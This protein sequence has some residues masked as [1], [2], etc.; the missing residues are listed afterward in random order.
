MSLVTVAEAKAQLNIDSA[1]TTY[2]TELQTYIDATT[3]VVEVLAGTVVPVTRTNEVY[4]P[5]GRSRIALRKTPIVSISSV[6]EYVGNTAYTLTSQ[7]LASTTDNYGYDLVDSNGGILVRRGA[8]GNE[9]PFLGDV[10]VTYQAGYASTPANVKLAALELIQ[11][12]WQN[13]QQG[14][15]QAGSEFAVEDG[16]T[17]VAGFNVP[18]QIVA[19]LA[20]TPSSPRRLP[21]I[22]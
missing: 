10:T 19:M 16:V 13:S 15:A 7:P 6:K 5:N 18:N 21:G 11:H 2:D 1:D 22:A 3:A 14:F 4:T 12:W 17:Q 20:A 9:M 8:S